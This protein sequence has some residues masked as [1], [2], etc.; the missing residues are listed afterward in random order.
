MRLRAY[1][2]YYNDP[3]VLAHYKNSGGLY[4]AETVLLSQVKEELKDQPILDVGIGGGRTTPYL[5]E[6][7][8]SYTGIDFSEGM[9]QSARQKFPDVSLFVCD[10]RDLSIF[11]DG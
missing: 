5:R 6:I 9:I 7:S 1:Q 2:T 10:A 4:P 11:H 8:K 3:A